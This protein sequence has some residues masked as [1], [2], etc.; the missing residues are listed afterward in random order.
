[1]VGVFAAAVAFVL[2][3]STCG[4]LPGTTRPPGGTGGAAVALPHPVGEWLFSGDLSDSSGNGNTGTS[5]G[6]TSFNVDRRGKPNAALLV[7]D[8]GGP[9]VDLGTSF[10]FTDGSSF[11]VSLWFSAA[12]YGGVN[13]PGLL[14]QIAAN[15]G[16]FQYFITIDGAGSVLQTQVGPNGIHSFGVATPFSLNT[17]H[18][19]VMVYD[20]TLQTVTGYLDGVSFGAGSASYA[21]TLHGATGPLTLGGGN[22]APAF[23]GSL[24]DVKIYSVALTA[25]QVAT[26]YSQYP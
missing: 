15:T 21:Y 13:Y 20:G 3:L 25:G 1:M 6:G 18:N 14:Y 5:L 22:G 24:D 2:A 12:A 19:V 26:L 4:T 8:V 23:T 9:N 17:W 10:Q 7:S 11:T 16:E